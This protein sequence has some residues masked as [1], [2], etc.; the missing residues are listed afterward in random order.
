MVKKE[1][2]SLKVIEKLLERVLDEL[3]IEMPEDMLIETPMYQ[4]SM[5]PI[6]T[7]TFLEMEK[8]VGEEITLIGLS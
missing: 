6:P 1:K 2:D 3:I 8:I 5:L 7:K 4:D